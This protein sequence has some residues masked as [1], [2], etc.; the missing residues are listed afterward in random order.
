M[1]ACSFYWISFTLGWLVLCIPFH[2]EREVQNAARALRELDLNKPSEVYLLGVCHRNFLLDL[3]PENAFLNQTCILIFH[4][5]D[6]LPRADF[7]CDHDWR[8][9]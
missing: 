8:L 1:N 9:R 6:R 3:T 5:Q 2:R 7:E 4:P